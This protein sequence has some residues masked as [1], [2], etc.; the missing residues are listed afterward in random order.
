M[1]P[2]LGLTRRRAGA[3]NSGMSRASRIVIAGGAHHVTQRGNHRQAVFA[4]DED[5]EVLLE[6]TGYVPI[7]PP[8]LRY[9][10]E[11]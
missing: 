3:E 4:A 6:K 1:D 8:R 9:P 10:Q 2:V 11:Q 7:S 5:R